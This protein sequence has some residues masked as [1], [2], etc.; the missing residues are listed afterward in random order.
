CLALGYTHFLRGLVAFTAADLFRE[1][2]IRPPG[3]SE[4]SMLFWNGLT[5][6]FRIERAFVLFGL[7][8]GAWAV[9]GRS[10]MLRLT[11]AAFLGVAGL[12][13]VTGVMH[14]YHP[15]WFGPAIW[16]F[17]GFLFPF[18]AIFSMVLVLDM[19]HLARRLLEWSCCTD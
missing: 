13:L 9:M 19:L 6:F 17:E 5:P 1:L 4:V 2:S 3:L 8:G 16:F 18:H 15:F 12:Y 14:R 11:A 7:L 10:G